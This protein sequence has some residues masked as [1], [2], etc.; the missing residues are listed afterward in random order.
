MR[1]NDEN[2]QVS[3][4]TFT[5]A[6]ITQ[7]SE[8]V[9]VVTPLKLAVDMT[10]PSFWPVYSKTASFLGDPNFPSKL[11]NDATSRGEKIR[12]YEDL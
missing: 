2:G 9:D 8:D 1:D 12:L 5:N 10:D 11:S 4:S 6:H 7:P 3:H